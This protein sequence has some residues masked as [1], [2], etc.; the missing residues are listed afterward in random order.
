MGA[1]KWTCAA[2][3]QQAFVS[4]FQERKFFLP[5]GLYLFFPWPMPFS[6]LAHIFFSLAYILFEEGVRIGFPPLEG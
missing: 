1:Q 5:I 6:S 2:V 3:L 4:F